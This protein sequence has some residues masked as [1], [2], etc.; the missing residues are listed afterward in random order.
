MSLQP[1]QQRV[2]DEKTELD[3]KRAK[4]NGFFGSVIFSG[5]PKDEQSRLGHQIE[6]MDQ[7]SLILFERIAAFSQ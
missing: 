3:D 6:A 4:L 5:L 2:V 1:H 7:Y